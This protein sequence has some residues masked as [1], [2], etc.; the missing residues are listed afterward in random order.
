VIVGQQS[1]GKSSLLQS[2]TDIPFPVG[3][4]LC[5]RFATRIISRRTEP[6]TSERIDISIETGDIDP[7]GY[8]ENAGPTR[9]FSHSLPAM[10]AEIF[11]KTVERASREVL[12]DYEG[13]A[14][15]ETGK[16]IHGNSPRVR[17]Q[18][19]KLLQQGSEN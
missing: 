18:E 11:E 5:T 8:Q 15:I 10:T 3:G 14:D 12:H 19:E 4:G 1:A 6:G 7:F 16:P 13:K 2:L 17:A 9:D